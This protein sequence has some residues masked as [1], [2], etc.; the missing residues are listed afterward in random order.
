MLVMIMCNTLRVKVWGVLASRGQWTI[1]GV[2]CNV[3]IFIQLKYLDRADH[4]AGIPGILRSLSRP[5]PKSSQRLVSRGLQF[6][7]QY[8]IVWL[9][10][11]PKKNETDTSQNDKTCSQN[12]HWHIYR[13]FAAKFLLQILWRY[14]KIYWCQ[15]WRTLLSTRYSCI[16][17]MPGY[18]KDSSSN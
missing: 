6:W 4:D 18:H 7:H 11:F 5:H 12:L 8:N 16:K 14:I 15:N 3:A 10:T 13:Q 9:G 2:W 1:T 17:I